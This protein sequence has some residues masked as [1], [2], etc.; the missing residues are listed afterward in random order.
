MWFQPCKE[1]KKQWSRGLGD[2][3]L[4]H[5]SLYRKHRA[6]YHHHGLQRF[7]RV[8]RRMGYRA[9]HH[10]SSPLRTVES[11]KGQVLLG[12]FMSSISH[13]QSL[14]ISNEVMILTAKRYSGQCTPSSSTSVQVCFLLAP[15]SV[16]MLIQD[17]CI[18]IEY[19]SQREDGDGG[20]RQPS[21]NTTN[22]LHRRIC[23]LGLLCLHGVVI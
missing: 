4:V 5:S 19:W 18:R 16:S 9:G 8:V 7:G 12:W 17:R 6:T 15:C 11:W 22:R 23:C 21:R 2:R 10:C 13:G 20:A 14:C 3:G 1:K